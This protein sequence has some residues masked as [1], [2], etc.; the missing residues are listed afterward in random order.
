MAKKKNNQSLLMVVIIIAVVIL[1]MKL[2]WSKSTLMQSGQFVEKEKANTNLGSNLGAGASEQPA[3]TSPNMCNLL[4]PYVV[5][6]NLQNLC[7][8]NGGTWVCNDN[9]IGCYTLS[10]S[11]INCDSAVVKTALAQCTAAT[12][13]SYCDTQTISCKY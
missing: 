6:F 9:N 2:D 13:K 11:T 8:S 12:G 4:T 3:V 5:V 10:N 1:F 7:A